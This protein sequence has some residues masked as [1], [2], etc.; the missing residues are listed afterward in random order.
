MDNLIGKIP[1]AEFGLNSS[2][3]LNFQFLLLNNNIEFDTQVKT[4]YGEGLGF[5]VII[6][7]VKPL[8]IEKSK[9][10]KNKVLTENHNIKAYPKF[11]KTFWIMIILI[12]VAVVSAY[13][14]VDYY[15]LAYPSR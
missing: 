9:A 11:I 6:F 2:I 12:T 10:L 14:I 1:V 15:D 3:H 4:E 7:F 5:D 8:D 13:F